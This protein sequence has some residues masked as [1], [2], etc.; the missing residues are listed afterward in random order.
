MTYQILVTFLVFEL[1]CPCRSAETFTG[2]VVCE[3]LQAWTWSSAQSGQS[4]WVRS[5][6][7]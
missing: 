6:C 2:H 1:G 4:I 5:C 3:L 7:V